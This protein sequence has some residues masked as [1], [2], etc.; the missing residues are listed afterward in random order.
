M[1]S[2]SSFRN[3]ASRFPRQPQAPAL[4]SCVIVALYLG[5]NAM[6]DKGV[7][8]LA[9]GLK[10]ARG[11]QKLHLNDNEVRLKMVSKSREVGHFAQARPSRLI[12]VSENCNPA[13][14]STRCRRWSLIRNAPRSA[15]LTLQI[16]DVGCHRL[17]NALGPLKVLSTLDLC[18]NP[19]GDKACL[20]LATYLCQPACPLQSLSVAGCLDVDPAAWKTIAVRGREGMGWDPPRPGDDGAVSLAAALMSP[21]GCP[22]R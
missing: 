16:T 11:L 19:F 14:Y 12:H 9:D 6:G 10:H 21:H 7:T 5:N 4:R 3:E 17:A 13:I 8:F 2:R 22:L 18:H 20:A 15:T 1:V